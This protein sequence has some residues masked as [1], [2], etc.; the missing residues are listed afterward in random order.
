VHGKL[1]R[2]VEKAPQDRLA[3]AALTAASA[4]LASSHTLSRRLQW[5]ILW[6]IIWV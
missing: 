2:A 5:I 6:Q 1:H 3:P 4:V